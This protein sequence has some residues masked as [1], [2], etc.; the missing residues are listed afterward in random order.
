[1]SDATFFKLRFD[2]HLLKEEFLKSTSKTL[3]EDENVGQPRTPFL[4][5]RHLALC[6]HSL[7]IPAFVLRVTV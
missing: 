4:M 1:M 5:G 7:A 2:F 6:S 3:S